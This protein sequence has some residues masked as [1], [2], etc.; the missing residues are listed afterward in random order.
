[1]VV[2]FIANSVETARGILLIQICIWI[3]RI[4][5]LDNKEFRFG[6]NIGSLLTIQFNSESIIFIIYVDLNHLMRPLSKVEIAIT[7]AP[8]DSPLRQADT[9]LSFGK[10]SRSILL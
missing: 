6:V 4:S 5:T 3:I 10:L 8:I 1:M 9:Y 7:V 2:L